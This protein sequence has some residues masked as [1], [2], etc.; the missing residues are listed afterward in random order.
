MKKTIIFF[1]A[2]VFSLQ[3]GF[4]QNNKTGFIHQDSRIEKL[5]KKHIKANSQKKGMLGYR[6]QIYSGSGANA[7]KQAMAIRTKFI[8]NFPDVK[9]ELIY[10]EPNFKLRIGNF[11]TK[12][13]G[14]KLYK[15][16]LE[17]FPGSY[18]IIEENMDFPEVK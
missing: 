4:G 1:I 17:Q 10:Q 18:F 8:V 9:T 5:V 13:E 3:L 7:R 16:L 2:I 6:I 12:S 15:S 14:Y 11:R